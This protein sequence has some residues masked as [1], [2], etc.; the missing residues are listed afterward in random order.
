MLIEQAISDTLQKYKDDHVMLD[1][2]FQWSTCQF[3]RKGEGKHEWAQEK[4]YEHFLNNL[5]FRYGLSVT[6]AESIGTRLEEECKALTENGQEFELKKAIGATLSGEIGD[7]LRNNVLSKLDKA[8]VSARVL[9]AIYNWLGSFPEYQY[10]MSSTA[11]KGPLEA[12]YRVTM[13][14]LPG[15]EVKSFAAARD[16]LISCGAINKSFYESST[17]KTSYDE[18]L[19]GILLVHQIDLASVAPKADND[20]I[21]TYLQALFTRL[22]FEQ[23]RIL[24]EVALCG[25]TGITTYDIYGKGALPG[26]VIPYRGLFA[27]VDTEGGKVAAVNPLSR[28]ILLKDMLECKMLHLKETALNIETALNRLREQAWPEA[29]LTR[30]SDRPDRRIWRLDQIRTP[31]L[32]IFIGNWLSGSDLNSMRSVGAEPSQ[33]TFMFALINQSL[34]SIKKVISNSFKMWEK[35]SITI[36][37]PTPKGMATHQLQGVAHPSLSRI[38]ELLGVKTPPPPPPP[39]VKYR[40]EVRVTNTDGTSLSNVNVNIGSLSYDTLS[41]GRVV[42]EVSAGTYTLTA[43]AKGYESFSENIII[44][45]NEQKTIRLQ[46]KAGEEFNVVFSVKNQASNPLEGVSVKVDSSIAATTDPTGTTMMNIKSGKYEVNISKAGYDTASETIEVTRDITKEFILI[47]AGGSQSHRERLLACF[48][49]DYSIQQP[50]QAWLNLLAERL[51]S[52]LDELGIPCEVNAKEFQ[53]GPR[54]VRANVKLSKGRRIKEVVSSALDIANKLFSCSELFQFKT[55]DESSKSVRVESNPTKGMVGIYI[56]RN[57]FVAVPLGGVIR[58]LPQDNP[59]SFP[60]GLNAIGQVQFSNLDNMPHLLVAG[61]TGA[62]KSVFLNCMIISLALQND[63]SQLQFVLIDPK[64]GLEFGPYERLPHV[65]QGKLVTS[66][67]LTVETLASARQEMD[68][69]YAMMRDV[70][71]SGRPVKKIQEYNDLPGIK[72]LPFRIII[73]DEFA[74]LVLSSYG[75]QI[76]ELVQA[77]AQ[78]GRAAG[79]YM[80]ICTQ[81]PSVKVIPGDIKAVVPSRISFR[82]PASFDSK[83]ILDEPGQKIYWVGVICS[84]RK[85]FTPSYEDFKVPSYLTMKLKHS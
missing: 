29:D 34:P 25:V 15:S 3:R 46:Q 44:A 72:P 27:Y 83:V 48:A 4:A 68:D 82:L 6:D 39:P 53:W 84:L 61:Q 23:A 43:T 45:K 58:S 22:S 12:L 9:L 85:R 33:D 40:V 8:S 1:A 60:V 21:S 19:P 14:T 73:V 11:W 13:G 37:T 77:L 66:P 62:G 7:I 69:R 75:S 56:P 41:E 52:I 10:S 35:A 81:R 36:I 26:E 17:G 74:D 50:D 28:E 67:E 5:S 20:G 78:K 51:K 79:F 64:G 2:F 65:S 16:E 54:L 49:N 71:K 42:L 57:D 59:L 31:R 47:D 70:A 32:F 80:V 55:E 38:M 63:P 18:Y 24:E 76:I 30:L